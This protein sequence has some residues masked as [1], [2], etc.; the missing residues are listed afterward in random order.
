[1]SGT[2]CVG[3]GRTKPVK[4]QSL[5]A[6]AAKKRPG[7]PAKRPLTVSR[8]AQR[9]AAAI[10]EVLAGVRTPTDAAAALAIPLPRYY[11]LEQRAVEGLVSA[12]EPRPMGRVASQQHQIADLQKEVV[13]LRKDCARQ[14]ALV[15]ASQRTI[16][17][18]PS[19]PPASKPKAKAAGTD[20][21]GK[22]KS[23][24]RRPTVRA[25]K[26]AAAVRAAP[27]ID[28]LPADSSL[29]V[30]AEVVEPCILSSP[31]LPAAAAPAVLAVPET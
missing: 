2:T 21:Q 14:Q 12:C 8:E 29:A 4:P 9:C 1:M 16:G 7:R 31:P 17:L 15:R 5:E 28:E 10:L 18:A 11:L 27:V 22:G 26:A 3:T 25:M 24:K 13:R 19:S 6:G 20:S 30:A 23:R